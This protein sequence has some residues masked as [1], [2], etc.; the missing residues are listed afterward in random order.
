MPKAGT[1]SI[2]AFFKSS[3]RAVHYNIGKS[4]KAKVGTCIKDAFEKGK[5]LLKTCGDYDV[6]AQIDVT[7]PGQAPMGLL[8]SANS[9]SA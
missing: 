6:W 3:T 1:S 4:K 7:Q 8:L 5:P 9:Q 2:Y